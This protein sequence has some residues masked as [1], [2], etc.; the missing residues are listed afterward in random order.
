MSYTI[1][2]VLRIVL[3]GHVSLL[4]STSPLVEYDAVLTR[5]T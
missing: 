3:D 2:P 5:P 4:I 1:A